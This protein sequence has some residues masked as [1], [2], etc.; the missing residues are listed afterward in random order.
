MVASVAEA[1][2]AAAFD[3]EQVLI[4]LMLTL[5]NGYP[6]GELCIQSHSPPIVPQKQK[7]RQLAL[8]TDWLRIFGQCFFARLETRLEKNLSK[9]GV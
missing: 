4:E 1:D 3:G 7:S 5:T 9:A 8:L 2:N 6:G